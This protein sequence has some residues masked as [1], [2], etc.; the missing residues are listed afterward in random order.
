MSADSRRRTAPGTPAARPHRP[1]AT[2]AR[3][4]RAQTGGRSPDGG[5]PAALPRAG[6]AATRSG[7]RPRAKRQGSS[8]ARVIPTRGRGPRLQPGARG[9]GSDRPRARSLPL[10]AELDP[11]R[12][13]E[14]ARARAELLDRATSPRR[15]PHQLDPGER[16]ERADQH[17]RADPAGSQTAFSIAW[18]P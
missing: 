7:R 6:A 8:V 16:L 3:K 4:R 5:G 13:R 11:E 17:R 14:L 2:P 15:A 12:L 9:R 18:M 10:C 1:A